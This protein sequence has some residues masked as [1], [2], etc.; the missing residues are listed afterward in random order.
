MEV[1]IDIP[2]KEL[3][4]IEH[5]EVITD[6]QR[7]MLFCAI[8]NGIILPKGHGRLIEEKAALNALLRSGFLDIHALWYYEDFFKHVKTIIPADKDGA[9]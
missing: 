1:V 7:A 3:Y 4:K 6:E 9:E 8:T 5:D 2:E